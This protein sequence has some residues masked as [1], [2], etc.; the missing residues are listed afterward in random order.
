MYVESVG[1][2]SSRSSSDHG[3]RPSSTKSRVKTNGTCPVSYPISSRALSV[4]PSTSGPEATT[5]SPTQTTQSALLLASSSWIAR[6]ELE[7]RRYAAAP[8]QAPGPS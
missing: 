5:S 8:T 2:A 7:R 4:G 3:Q 1:Y 6:R